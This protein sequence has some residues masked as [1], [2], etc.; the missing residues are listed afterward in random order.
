MVNI[1]NDYPLVFWFN[2][3]LIINLQSVVTIVETLS[4]GYELT[5]TEGKAIEISG[6][7]TV[8]LKALLSL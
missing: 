1:D 6:R 7:N 5:M 8:K 2:R 4:D 3:Q